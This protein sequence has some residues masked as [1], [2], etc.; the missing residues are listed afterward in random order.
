[1]HWRYG[2]I[3][4]CKTCNVVPAVSTSPPGR[5]PGWRFTARCKF[6]MALGMLG[7]RR[8]GIYVDEFFWKV[9]FWISFTNLNLSGIFSQLSLVSY[10]AACKRSAR[11]LGWVKSLNKFK[12]LDHY[13]WNFENH[14]NL[15]KADVAWPKMTSE[16]SKSLSWCKIKRSA[17][18]AL[19]GPIAA[20][21]EFCISKAIF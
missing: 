14:K 11:S 20:L 9:D 21:H 17:R 3:G 16:N 12:V 2:G 13:V 1:M 15:L 4:G 7:G 18:P 5:E 8:A 10:L 6:F 19:K